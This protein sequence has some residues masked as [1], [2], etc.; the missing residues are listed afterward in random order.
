[1]DPRTL[2]IVRQEISMI[3]RLSWALLVIAL[4]LSA[5]A[6]SAQQA[7]II[8]EFSSVIPI[9]RER[10]YAIVADLDNH[11]RLLRNVKGRIVIPPSDLAGEAIAANEVIAISF[12][13]EP[14]NRLA[15][16]RFR[17]FPPERIEEEI[18]T[19]PFDDVDILD[20]KKAK[21]KYIFEEDAGGTKF[22]AQS[23]FIPETSRIYTQEWVDNIWRDFIRNLEAL[24]QQ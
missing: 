22:T 14:S 21:V 10:V 2:P 20:K 18:V 11:P 17:F 13:F 9:P 19:S 15:I 16:T 1:L 3:A 4:Q 24:A 23:E 8:S 5:G 6:A 7:P 12:V